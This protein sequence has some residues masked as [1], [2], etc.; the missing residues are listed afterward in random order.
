MSS[1]SGYVTE[2][3]T[4]PPNYSFPYHRMRTTLNDDSKTPVVLVA[5]GSFS[6]VTY[7]HLRMFEMARDYIRHNT[8]F[9]IVGA[10][11]S[12]VSDMYKKPGL[13]NARHRVN[14][15][16]LAAEDSGGW[17]MVDSWEAF[18]SYQRTAIVLDHFDYEINTVR[19]GV[20]TQSGE[21]RNV[22][23]MLLAGSDLISTMS[24][25]GVWSY[26]DLEHILGRYG[27]FI[28]ERA[29]SGMDQATD[30]LAKWRHNIYMISQLIQN[31]VSSTKVRLFLRRGLSV[32]Y[33]LP[34]SV[35]DYIEAHGLYQDE[36]INAANSAEK[37]KERE[38][39]SAKKDS[40]STTIPSAP[41]Q[42][43]STQ[44]TKTQSCRQC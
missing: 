22:R 35:V 37:G 8:E 44:P 14:M 4:N 6:P 3:F 39:S 5:C 17:L 13:L 43:A 9:E 34:N 24:E 31:D 29:G 33:L 7:L 41:P 19:G 27:V 1:T 18:Q 40:A 20:K 10:Y 12:P 28:V 2:G 16:N 15:C 32:R 23:V 26:S 21:Q 25:P 38:A 36:S 11:L 30:N 42:A